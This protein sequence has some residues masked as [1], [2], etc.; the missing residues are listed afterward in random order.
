MTDDLYPEP[1]HL[2]IALYPGTAEHLA[3]AEL[4]D[5]A[6]SMGCVPN[7]AAE[8]APWDAEFELRSDLADIAWL[9]T[10]ADLSRAALA[11]RRPRDGRILQAGFRAKKMGGIAVAQYLLAR[12]PDRHPV[13]IAIAGQAFGLPEELWKKGDRSNAAKVAEWSTSLLAEACRRCDPPYA[14]M[15]V[16]LMFDTPSALAAGSG[17]ISTELY[18][19]DRVLQAAKPL[20]GLLAE[21]FDGGAILQ[22][23]RGVFH[24]GRS[25]Q[26]HERV[27]EA[28]KALGT[29][30]LRLDG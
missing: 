29:A 28:S 3:F 18:V 1:P 8:V 22:W 6:Q 5:I 27:R 15:G 12:P 11:A 7:G 19:S 17:K 2:V 25:P 14:Q 9:E 26:L 23:E 4:C 13:A 20:R 24:S 21:S 16:E 10:R 30:V